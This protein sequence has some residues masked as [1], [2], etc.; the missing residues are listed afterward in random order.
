MWAGWVSLPNSEYKAE[1]RQLTAAQKGPSPKLKE[2]ANYHNLS[3][4]RRGSANQLID[5]LPF[6]Y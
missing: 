2:L 4:Q 1:W 3:R 5:K 6:T